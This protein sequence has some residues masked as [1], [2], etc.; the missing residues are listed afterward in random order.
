[1]SRAPLHLSVSFVVLALGVAAA[2]GIGLSGSTQIARRASHGSVV[3]KAA[4][5]RGSRTAAEV[6]PPCAGSQLVA[7]VPPGGPTTGVVGLHFASMIIQFRNSGPTCTT[8][9]WPV[10][11]A[12]DPATN[13]PTASSLMDVVFGPFGDISA[14]SVTVPSRGEAQFF[15]TSGFTPS[16][17]VCYGHA[18]LQ[19]SAPGGGAPTTLL[20][21]PNTIMPCLGNW[22]DISPVTPLGVSFFAVYPAAQGA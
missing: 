16:D 3:T 13:L 22:I 1:V 10:V 12:L 7:V 2:V 6:A 8:S 18:T 17:N 21:L 9:G 20:G 11:E 15:L 19:V 14:T 5:H 4:V